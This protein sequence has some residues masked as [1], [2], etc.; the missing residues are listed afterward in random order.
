MSHE[1]LQNVDGGIMGSTL[2]KYFKLVNEIKLHSYSL[3]CKNKTKFYQVKM[4]YFTRN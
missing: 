2:T 3:R 1:D 4:F